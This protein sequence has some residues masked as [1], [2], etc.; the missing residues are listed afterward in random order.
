MNRRQRLVQERF[1]DNEEAVIRELKRLYGQSLNDIAQRAKEL[2]GQID[3]LQTALDGIED[4]VERQRLKS[5]IQSKVYQKQY[6]EALKKQI[7]SIL[8][9]MH[10][11]EFKTVSGYLKRCYEDG[12]M[13][14]MYDISGQGIL[15]II[16]L[17]QEAMIRAVQLDSKLSSGLYSRLGEDVANLKRK[18]T[19]QI[20]RGVSTGMSFQQMGQQLAGHTN[21]GYNN[22]V[23]IARTEGHRVQVQSGMDACAR[24]KENGCDV[25]KQWDATLDART[26]DS[27][28]R[29]DGEIRELD[30]KFSN[31]LMFPGDPNGGAAEVVNCRCA[32]LQRARWALDADELSALKEQAEFFGLDKAESFAQFRTKYLKAAENVEKSGGSGII[33]LGNVNARKWYIDKVSKIQDGIDANLPMEERARKAFEERSRIRAEARNMMIDEVARKKL[34]IERPNKSFEELVESKMIRKGMTRD[35]AIADIY[36]TAIKTNEAVNKK[37]GLEGD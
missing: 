14:A 8:D 36:K 37:L 33:K 34:E 23:R 27:H 1:L 18:V 6:Q 9:N 11:E 26:R 29:V 30:K 10:V 3:G 20:S 31:G 15:L 28:A 4:A 35:E 5:M 7:G 12:F 19:A 21:I 32:L 17:D 16:P 22:A 13:G 24:A 2:Q 25:V